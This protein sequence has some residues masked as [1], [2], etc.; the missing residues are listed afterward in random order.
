M[1]SFNAHLMATINRLH[2]I[3]LT[4]NMWQGK[5]GGCGR[6]EGIIHLGLKNILFRKTGFPDDF[7]R[8]ICLF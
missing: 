6:V 7:V 2:L 1:P 3:C 5:L 8:Q 4:M